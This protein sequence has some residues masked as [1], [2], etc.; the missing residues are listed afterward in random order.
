MNST[1]QSQ[2]SRRQFLKTSTTAA[3]GGW[4]AAPAILGTKSSAASPGD[5]LKIGLIGAGGRGSGAAQNALRADKNNVVTAIADVYEDAA[6]RS[7]KNL[8][9]ADDVGD[10]VSV[11]R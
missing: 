3:V 5:T 11:D 6:G 8:K 7:L 2:T 10:Q 9:A 1:P 4:M